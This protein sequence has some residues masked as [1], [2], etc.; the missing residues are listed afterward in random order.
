MNCDNHTT[1]SNTRFLDK[2]NSITLYKHFNITHTN[3]FKILKLYKKT[4]IT[5]IIKYVIIYFYCFCVNI[6]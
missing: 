4:Y 5:R 2:N 6:I 1:F 3:N